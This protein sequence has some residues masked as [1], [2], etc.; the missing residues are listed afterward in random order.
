MG[1]KFGDSKERP[2]AFSERGRL[3]FNKEVP[4]A[5][6]VNHLAVFFREQE[7]ISVHQDCKGKE[8]EPCVRREPDGLNSFGEAGGNRGPEQIMETPEGRAHTER[9]RVRGVLLPEKL[10]SVVE[11]ALQD[12]QPDD[13]IRFTSEWN[14]FWRSLGKNQDGSV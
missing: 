1:L 10:A 14:P 4:S 6:V 13:K 7:A 5:G 3:A 12:A 9:R 8:V 11:A 2:G